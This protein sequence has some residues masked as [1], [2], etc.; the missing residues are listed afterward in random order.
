[1]PVL[2]NKT[3]PFKDPKTLHHFLSS[4]QQRLDSPTAFPL[5]TLSLEI[6][7]V[8]PLTVLQTAIQTNTAHFYLE[9][10]A[11]GEAIASLG[12]AH[13]VTAEGVGRFRTIQR[14]L[15][16]LNATLP[17]TENRYYGCSF[18]FFEDGDQAES[19]FAPAELV[20]PQWQIIRRQT[21]YRAIAHLPL[22]FPRR[23]DQFADDLWRQF[24]AITQPAPSRFHIPDALAHCPQFWQLTEQ[25]DFTKSVTAALAAIQQQQVQKLVLAHALDVL[26]PVPF[27]AYHSLQQLRRLYPDCY[28]FSVNNGRGKTFLGASPETLVQIQNQ[29]LLTDA[30]AG[31]AARG[32]TL[33]ADQQ[34]AQHLLSSPKERHEHQIVVDFLGDRL[35]QLGINPSHAATPT[36]LRLSNI[37]HLHTPI[38]GA[39]PSHLSPLDLVAALH[40]TPAVAGIPPQ[41]ALDLIRHYES[42]GR[43]LYA[44]PIGWLDAQ[45]N[46]QFVVGIRSAML[47]GN[48]ARL[49]AG[50]GIVSGSNPQREQ[51]EVSL[52]LQ[53]LLRAL[54]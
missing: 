4:T 32:K 1:M 47:S 31:S 17:P 15:E 18:S 27:D 52:K 12:V 30:L 38:V 53:A 14:H 41:R 20:V 37:Q 5:A 48:H 22:P 29:Q 40:P 10:P 39:V 44:A 54:A 43:S 28:L 19:G 46:A 11:S 25:Q 2:P 23:L 51:A 3:H 33:E 35:T 6:D 34:L 8:D 24:Q 9:K 50:A 42:F 26:A 7:P 21:S 13:R 16:A 49:Y 45:G 36:L